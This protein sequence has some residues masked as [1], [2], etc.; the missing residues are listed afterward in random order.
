MLDTFQRRPDGISDRPQNWLPGSG[1]CSLP[2]D[3][4]SDEAPGTHEFQHGSMIRVYLNVQYDHLR[5]RL[6]QLSARVTAT[7]SDR[8]T[9]ACFS[10]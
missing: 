9:Q 3:E 8:P 2:D 5:D 10:S 1:R 6:V 7:A 4:P